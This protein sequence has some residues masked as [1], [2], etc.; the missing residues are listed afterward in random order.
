MVSP[1]G[2]TSY[3]GEALSYSDLLKVP[4]EKELRVALSQGELRSYFLSAVGWLCF[5]VPHSPHSCLKPSWWRSK[6]DVVMK[7][8]RRADPGWAHRSGPGP[9]TLVRLQQRGAP[10][11]GGWWMLPPAPGPGQG[12]PEPGQQNSQVSQGWGLSG[13]LSDTAWFLCPGC[14]AR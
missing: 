1:A 12:V 2:S 5:P 11:T 8:Y 14:K 9:H 13:C 6:V 4:A 7:A 3:K 10:D